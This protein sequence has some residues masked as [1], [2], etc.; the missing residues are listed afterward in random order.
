VA[1]LGVIT[2][3]AKM[4]Q[5]AVAVAIPSDFKRSWRKKSWPVSLVFNQKQR[6]FQIIESRH[7][8]A[9]YELPLNG[10]WPDRVQ[11]DGGAFRHVIETYASNEILELIAYP[12][13]LVIKSGK[14]P[15]SMSRLDAPGRKA[16]EPQPIPRDKRHKGPVKIKEEPFQGRVELDATWDFSARI[17]VPHHQ[18]PDSRLPDDL[19]PTSSKKKTKVNK[20]SDEGPQK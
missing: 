9:G 1:A 14:S 11:V 16:I 13:R 12:D 20:D 6:L 17:P 4:L 7:E 2:I 15:F 3:S 8:L 5:E 10:T 19:N 18:F